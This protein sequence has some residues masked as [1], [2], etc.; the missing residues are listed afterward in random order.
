MILITLIMALQLLEA[1]L[2]SATVQPQADQEHIDQELELTRQ[3]IKSLQQQLSSIQS[4][5]SHDVLLAPATLQSMLA[6]VK[7]QYVH[8]KRQ[9]IKLKTERDIVSQQIQKATNKL[10]ARAA[11]YDKLKRLKKDLQTQTERM[12]KIQKS[13]R[14][15]YKPTRNLNKEP[16]VLDHQGDVILAAPMDVRAKPLSFKSL[17]ELKDWISKQP[18]S[19]VY[20]MILFRPAASIQF[21][22]L[23]KFLDDSDYSYGYD[24]I[25]KEQIVIDP[26]D[27]AGV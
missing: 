20:F 6:D 9:Q 10:D 11:D 5:N 2:S 7:Q 26:V 21:D 27:G 16:W 25:G 17:Q 4:P 22:S 14:R 8:E 24:A 1:K 23:L 19:K 13:G 18:T 15:I 3:S 12:E